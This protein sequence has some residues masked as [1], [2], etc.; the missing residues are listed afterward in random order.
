MRRSSRE[1]LEEHKKRMIRHLA[2]DRCEITVLVLFEEDHECT[3]GNAFVLVN[4]IKEQAAS[5]AFFTGGSD[6]I[7]ND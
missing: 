2:E 1:I 3:R 7:L 5:K 4:E 6:E